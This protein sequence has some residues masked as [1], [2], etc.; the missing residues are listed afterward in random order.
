[1]AATKQ[2]L[3]RRL[4]KYIVLGHGTYQSHP[5]TFIV[6]ANTVFI[7]VSKASRYLVQSVI[8]DE[9]YNYFSSTSRNYT[10]VNK[11]T[12][13]L[14]KNLNT[15][16]YG[17]GE[18]MSDIT[19]SFKDPEWPGMG[20]HPLPINKNQFKTTKGALS[21]KTGTLSSLSEPG[22]F[23][24]VSCRA[25]QGQSNLYRNQRVNYLFDPTSTHARL[26]NENKISKSL[27]KRRS[28]SNSNSNSNTDKK[29]R[30]NNRM[31]M[32]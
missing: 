17:P 4:P 7:F 11:N 25:I 26:V 2:E 5:P 10:R 28:N 20:I 19:L 30:L 16:V 6:P 1:M 23:F 22:V 21:G 27:Y 29:R 8:T 3:I 31:N 9:F 18:R 15:R 24:I 12:P 13:D 32:S 14:F